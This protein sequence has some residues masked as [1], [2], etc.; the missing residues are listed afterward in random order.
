MT[1][2]FWMDAALLPTGWANRTR[3]SVE[4]GVI[5]SIELD[6][7]PRVGDERCGVIVP[8]V[9]NLH[10]HAFQRAMAGLAEHRGD[11]SDSFWTWRDLMYRFAQR[12]DPEG[13]RA[14]AALAFMEMLEGGFVRVGEFHYLHH[15]PS[16]A[17]YD[18]VAEM[19]AAIIAAAEETGIALTLLPVLYAASGFGGS[20]PN[21][22]QRRFVNG[23]EAF[24]NLLEAIETA[25][26]GH[27]DIVVGLAPHSLRAV[28]PDLLR[29]VVR[30]RP[31]APVHIHVA[32]QVQEVEDCIKWSGRRPVEWLLDEVEVSDRWC[33]VHA[34]HVTDIELARIVASGS[35]VGLCPITEAN[36]GD[37]I[38]PAAGLLE[39]GGRF[40]IG[41]DSNVRIGVA[42]ELALLEYGQRLV[43][44]ERNVLAQPGAA[45]GRSLFEAAIE[46][47]AVTLG[48]GLCGI[49]PGAPADFVQLDRAHPSLVHRNGDALLDSWIFASGNPAVEHVWRRGRKVVEGG[50]HH[51]RERIVH[52]YGEALKRLMD[53]E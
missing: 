39:Q 6:V 32:E 22:T 3:I 19:S 46:G 17:Y 40:G 26:T 36:L 7:T 23:L 27:P 48:G 50:R 25:A 16:G 34:T 44:R 41:T 37:G 42:N 51:A 9:P 24:N 13:M 2:T 21:V 4:A 14:I 43:R 5:Q 45:T 18:N 12:L 53:E 8:G 52:R 35:V 10:S 47:G 38:F 11:R 29:D 15:Q 20:I 28:P 30:L 1:K 33:L 49:V 31:H